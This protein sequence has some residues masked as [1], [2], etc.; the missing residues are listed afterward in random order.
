MNLY[1]DPPVITSEDKYC[2]L[3]EAMVPF[4]PYFFSK[5]RI[6]SEKS[7]FPYIQKMGENFKH[8]IAGRFYPFDNC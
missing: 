7:L 1:A 2:H 3:K 4:V 8:F 5:R 6:L